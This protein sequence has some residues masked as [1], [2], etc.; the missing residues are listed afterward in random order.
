LFI[1]F[2]S[3]VRTGEYCITAKKFLN[4]AFESVTGCFMGIILFIPSAISVMQNPRVDD[5][6]KGFGIWMYTNVQQYFAILASALLPP[7]PP[8]IPSLFTNGLVKWT[9][10]SAFVALGGLFGLFV[11][12][13]YRK[14][15]AFYKAF[16]ASIICAFVPVLN[17]MFY[18][19]NSSYYAR[20][21]YMPVLMLVAMN[22][23]SFAM[24]KE[25]IFHGLKC[26]AILTACLLPFGLTPVKNEV[27][28]KLFIGLADQVAI[29]WLNILIAFLS[30]Y[31]LYFI[32]SNSK[33][34]PTYTRHLMSGA[35]CMTMLFGVLHMGITKMPQ[36]ESDK[37]YR[38]QNYDILDTMDFTFG[39]EK[40]DWRMD[41]FNCYDNLGLFSG[42]PCIQF[43]NS[44]VSPS[45]MEFYPEVGVKR[46]VSSKPQASLYALRSLLSVKYILMPNWEETNFLTDSKA[47]GYSRIS[48]DYPYTIYKNNDFIT[49]GFAYDRYVTYEQLE[50]VNSINRSNVLMRAI[51]VEEDI[52]EKYSLGLEKLQEHEI[53]DYTYS[54]FSSDLESRRKMS[55]YSFRQNPD[56]FSCNIWLDKGNLVFFSVPYDK[57]FAAY[58]NGEKSEVIKVNYGLCAVYAPA[59]DNEII[60]TYRTPGMTAGILL[61]LSGWA[62]WAGYLYMIKKQKIKEL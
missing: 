13:R 50:S 20:W 36:W 6:L 37:L 9:S 42:T 2:F 21:F 1:Y 54:T 27:E 38:P 25:K 60:F 29:Y 14:H 61:T 31:L 49:M 33:E 4:L 41:T 62:V 56:G 3:K 24:E 35:L 57:G 28:D 48:E 34:K 19:F 40:S 16:I 43:F 32:V 55:S 18:A 47:M 58:V 10:M 44:T 23:Q 51:A 5:T 45:I 12:S 59:G 39:E 53:Y 46:D 30:L 17:S 22:M 7:D 11:F 52:I 8:Y 26:T 15:S